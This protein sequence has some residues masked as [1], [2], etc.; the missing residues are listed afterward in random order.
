MPS[1]YEGFGL[2]VLEA[3]SC[4]TPVVAANSSSLPEVAGEAAV[5]VDPLSVDSI[6]EGIRRV[7]EDEVL[8]AE[9]RQKGLA[10]AKHFT[11]QEAAQKTL[12]ILQMVGRS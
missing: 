5:L 12:D 6:A 10:Q 1:L 7:V 4:A 11:W 3:M 2:P 9:L 8:Q